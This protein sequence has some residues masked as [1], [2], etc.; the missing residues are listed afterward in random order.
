MD[1]D[2]R[3]YQEFLN[4]NQTAFDKIMDKHAAR[5]IY[6]IF[7]FVKKYDVAE[8][9]AQDVFVYLLLNKEKYN[10][11]CALKTY[12]YLIARSRAINYLK[13]NVSRREIPIA[14]YQGQEEI[15]EIEEKVFDNIRDQNIRD[16]ISNLKPKD[17]QIMYL[18]KIEEMKIKEIAQVLN[19]T[20]SNVKVSI[21]RG[22]KRLK[23]ILGEEDD[24][25]V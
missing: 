2:K 4:G 22:M 16:A 7:G 1:E 25:Y 17:K 18:A 19:M 12:L 13:S 6:F 10:F 20:E 8:D 21:H 15:F 11:S 9:L 23:K 24:L 3:L 14:D 5:L